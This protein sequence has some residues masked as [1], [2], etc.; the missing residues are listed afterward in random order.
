[1]SCSK[2]T[3]FGGKSWE[4]KYI[5]PEAKHE[6]IL[7]CWLDLNKLD[8]NKAFVWEWLHLTAI[9]DLIIRYFKTGEKGVPFL[10][11]EFWEGKD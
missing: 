6:W 8:W 2:H 5:L 9:Y 3:I 10:P 7:L 1:M 4:S 11:K